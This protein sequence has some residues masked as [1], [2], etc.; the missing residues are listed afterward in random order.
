[1]ARITQRP[2]ARRDLIQH[3]LYLAE[4]A[5]LETAERFRQAAQHTYEELADMPQIGAPG[6]VPQGRF[7]GVRMWRVRGFEHYLIFYRPLADGVQIERVIHAAQDY[8]RILGR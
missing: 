4:H 7:A 1:M 3:F 2:A 5:G 8:Q 6:K